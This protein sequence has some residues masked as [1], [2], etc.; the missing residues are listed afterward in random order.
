MAHPVA[1]LAV[2][3]LAV[4]AVHVAAVVA[5]TASTSV[6]NDCTRFDCVGGVFV[7]TPGVGAV[8]A[9]PGALAAMNQ[10]GHS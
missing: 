6:L 1:V 7:V 9:T 4:T 2:V 3:V 8:H 10:L 5:L